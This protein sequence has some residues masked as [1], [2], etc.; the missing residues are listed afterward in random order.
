MKIAKSEKTSGFHTWTEDEIQQF[1]DYHKLGTRERLA[2]ELYLCT[3]QR[4]CDV[5]KMGM[6]QVKGEILRQLSTR[7]A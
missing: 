6:A 7:G 4:R 2:M 5:H 1:R 3:H